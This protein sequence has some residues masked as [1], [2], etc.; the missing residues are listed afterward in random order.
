M[1]EI[2]EI[3]KTLP[4]LFKVHR[5]TKGNDLQFA[6]AIAQIAQ[7]RNSSRSLKD[8]YWN[9]TI[10]FLDRRYPAWRGYPNPEYNSE[11]K[12]EKTAS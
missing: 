7:A 9:E 5:Q 12:L 4:E 2:D 3:V 6:S 8:V 10:D 11:R 1:D